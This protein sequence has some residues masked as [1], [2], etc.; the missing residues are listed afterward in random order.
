MRKGVFGKPLFWMSGKDDLKN[1]WCW[2]KASEAGGDS[3]RQDAR[4]RSEEG[5]ARASSCHR[6]VGA[7]DQWV[8]KLGQ[9][10]GL[11]LALMDI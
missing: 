8:V 11:Y 6:P 1:T 9:N 7:E 5:A 4:Q 10:A 2:R 3:G